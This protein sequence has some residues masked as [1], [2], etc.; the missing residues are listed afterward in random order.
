MP[1]GML[2]L[3]SG[4][5]WIC[6]SSPSSTLWVRHYRVSRAVTTGVLFVCG[7][8]LLWGVKIQVSSPSSAC[9]AR[10]HSPVLFAPSWPTSA[11]LDLFG[12]NI[13]SLSVA[14]EGLLCLG[15]VLMNWVVCL[16]GLLALLF[17]HRCLL[18]EV[19]T[20]VGQLLILG[21]ERR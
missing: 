5:K 3:L 14:L 8:G 4:C 10:S 16:L 19:Q 1:V 11:V 21:V 7:G 12:E 2:S 18:F 6:S 15:A 20:F 13:D 17:L 9:R